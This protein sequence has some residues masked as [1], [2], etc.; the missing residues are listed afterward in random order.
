MR[1]QPGEY[2]P[3]YQKYIDRVPV[4]EIVGLL[5]AAKVEMIAFLQAFPPDKWNYRYAEGKWSSREA[6]LHIIDTERIFSYRALRVAR[7]DQTLLPGFDQNAYVPAS[8]AD[9]RSWQSLLTE[10]VAVREATIQLFKNFTPE[11]WQHTG[12]AST[13]PISALALAHITYGHERHHL[14]IFKEHYLQ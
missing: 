6:L 8:N 2:A 14:F 11:M 9:N 7:N 10:Y 3:Y 1:P 12:I 4:G 5:E 13:F